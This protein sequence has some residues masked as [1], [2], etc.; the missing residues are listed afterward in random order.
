MRTEA[1]RP[2]GRL[3]IK[4][5]MSRRTVAQWDTWGQETAPHLESWN[6]SHT[7]KKGPGLLSSIHSFLPK[8]G[9][10]VRDMLPSL[11]AGEP[12]AE[13]VTGVPTPKLTPPPTLISSFPK[14]DEK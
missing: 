7:A 2:K 4:Q 8:L 12:R 11:T 14:F 10:R 1:G 5:S 9:L 13:L 3:V 6:L